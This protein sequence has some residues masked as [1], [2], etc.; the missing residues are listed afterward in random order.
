MVIK[1][2]KYTIL[3]SVSPT[4]ESLGKKEF[5]LQIADKA[6]YLIHRVVKTTAMNKAQFTSST[7][8]R[9]QVNG[10]GRKPWKQKGTGRARAG[11]TR[12]PLWR[13]GGVIFGPKMK[14][15]SKKI[16]KKEKQLALRTI[17]YNKQKQIIVFNKF[18]LC[19]PKTAKFLK[20]LVIETKNE[21]ILVI[22]SKPNQNLKLSVRNLQNFEYIM[23]N[24]LNVNALTKAKQIIVDESSFEVIKETYCSGN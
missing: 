11:S 16:N 13:G 1:T 5:S 10:G 3:D 7:K 9:S 17:L 12:S 15:I 18:E 23:A 24:Q 8:T 14:N 19:E 2:F 4:K 21:K 22:S 20:N 6:Q